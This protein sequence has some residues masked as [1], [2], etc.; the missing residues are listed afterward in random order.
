LHHVGDD[1][2]T[3]TMLP[4]V[5]TTQAWWEKTWRRSLE[6]GDKAGKTYQDPS[7]PSS[8]TQQ[9]PKILLCA[10]SSATISGNYV[11]PANYFV[12]VES[13]KT[14]TISSTVSP[15]IRLEQSGALRGLYTSISAALSNATSGQTV[16]VSSSQTVAGSTTI[17]N[18]VTLYINPGVTI[19][20][21]GDL[22][23]SSGATLIADNWYQTG[24]INLKFNGKLNVYG[25]LAAYYVNFLELSAGSF[26]GI[27]IQSNA[28][29]EITFCNIEDGYYGIA[30]YSGDWVELIGNTFTD[31]IQGFP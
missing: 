20:F 5:Y 15:D 2:S 8:I 6:N 9:I 4:T 10:P 30:T 3:Y 14:V 28:D 26:D 11:I 27:Y 1:F 12:S 17:P 29:A 25:T 24:A 16:R 13:G 22:T 21:N 31:C 23:V 18:G 19:N 7:F